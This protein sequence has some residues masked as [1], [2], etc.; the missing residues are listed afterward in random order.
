MRA[1]ALPASGQPSSTTAGLTLLAGCF[2]FAL[3]AAARYVRE[4]LR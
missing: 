2:G 4:R 1:G 3:Y